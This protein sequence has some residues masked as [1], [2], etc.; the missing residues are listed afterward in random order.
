[1]VKYAYTNILVAIQRTTP[2]PDAPQRANREPAL[3]GRVKRT[4]QGWQNGE[5]YAGCSLQYAKLII[6]A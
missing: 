2:L 4:E 6:A 3:I 5:E 1:M